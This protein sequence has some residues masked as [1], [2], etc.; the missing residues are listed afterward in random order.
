METKWIVKKCDD[1]SQ[2]FVVNGGEYP[3]I[4]TG[5]TLL[6][7][8]DKTSFCCEVVSETQQEQTAEIIEETTSCLDCFI[9]LRVSLEFLN[10][11]KDESII[12]DSG[13]F[14]LVPQINKVYSL[15]ITI[16]GVSEDIKNETLLEA[17]KPENSVTVKGCFTYIGQSLR[18]SSKGRFNSDVIEFDSCEKCSPYNYNL[19]DWYDKI[20][21]KQSNSRQEYL[22]II[23]NTPNI[24]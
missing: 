3:N 17:R 10:C 11:F 16:D 13:I 7:S 19:S 20:K 15:D 14:S 23:N 2:T 6:V 22:S 5:S 9:N 18:G 21:D 1:E 8:Y 12:L 4:T 24:K